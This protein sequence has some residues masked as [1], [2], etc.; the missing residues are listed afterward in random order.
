V[1]ATDDTNGGL[2]GLEQAIPAA[3]AEDLVLRPYADA[4]AMPTDFEIT[5]AA[6]RGTDTL[7]S[8]DQ[9]ERRQRMRGFEDTYVDIVDFIV[10][11]THRVWEEKDIGYIYDTYRH[12]ARVTDDSGLQYGRDKIVADTV[13]TI[14][15]FP[16]VRLYADEVIWA[17]DDERGFDTSHRTIIL[18]HNTGHSR[19]GP[20]T[21]RKVVVWA[22]ANCSARAN[23]IYEEWVLYNTSSLLRQLG[24]DLR[25]LARE[26]GNRSEVDALVDLRFGEAERVLGQGKPS[27][28]PSRAGDGFDPEDFVRRLWHY[29]WNWRNLA[30][31]D[32]AYAANVRWSGPTGRELY[33]RGDLKSFVL[34]LLAMF[35]DLAVGLDD[36]YWMGNDRDGYLVSARWSALGTHRGHGEYGPPTGRRV[37]L[38][39]I[40]QYRIAGG[41]IEQEW[42][43]F[44]EFD[45]LQQIH[46]DEPLA[47]A[48]HA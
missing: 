31:V 25:A 19:Y 5:V 40:S 11:V 18:G 43:L 39:G 3:D 38:W 14:N 24:F 44:N 9:G 48:A 28:L 6:K 30:T 32:R 47:V 35:P 33:G 7:L 15:A 46:R 10:R 2:A 37:V 17:G 41:R 8:P 20:P 34:S 29:A 13:Q 1:T 23:E 12:N 42:T 22:I 36:V 45:V 21:G 26:L 4:R 27:H 16:D